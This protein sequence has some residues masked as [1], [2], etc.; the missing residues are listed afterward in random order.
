MRRLPIATLLLSVAGFCWS[1]PARADEVPGPI[2]DMHVHAE[3]EIWAEE[4][5]CFPEPCEHQPTTLDR[6]EDLLPATLRAMKR[7]GIVLGVL[8]ERELERIQPWLD[9][10]PGTFIAGYQINNPAAVT[11]DQLRDLLLSKQVGVIGEIAVMYE[12]IAIDDPS[13]DPFFAL[14]QSLDVPVH[15]HVLGLGG[16]PRFPIHLGS[17]LRVARVMNR[18]PDLRIYLENAGWPFLDET[19]A[20][21]YQYPAVHA[22]LSTI[23]WAIPRP[24]FHGFLRALVESGLGKRLMFGSDAML[25]PEKIGLAVEAI[26]SADFLSDEQQRD[27]FYNNAARFLRL[28]E[29]Q[30]DRHHHQA[31]ANSGAHP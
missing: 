30:M 7:H 16:D 15:V 28:S 6:I 3:Y 5:L 29:E 4:A 11:V 27:I 14:A 8:S 1:S 22:D 25:W 2:I 26:R 18:Y 9:A 24:V 20:L 10:S 21:M 31:P 19:I 12:R 23:T 17:P 13:V